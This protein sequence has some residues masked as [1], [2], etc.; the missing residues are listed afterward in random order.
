MSHNRSAGRLRYAALFPVVVH[1]LNYCLLLLCA[2]TAGTHTVNEQFAMDGMVKGT[3]F[4]TTL[5]QAASE[6]DV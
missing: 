5:I 3:E 4:Y 1:E 2:R 6:T